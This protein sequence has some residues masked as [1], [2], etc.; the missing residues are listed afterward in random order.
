MLSTILSRRDFR[1][2]DQIISLYTLEQGKVEVLARGVKKI[3]SK[4]SAH[5]EPFSLIE[6]EIIPGK[7]LNHLGTVQP[8][9]YFSNIRAD[10][11]KSLASSFIIS[12]LDKILHA[13]ERDERIFILLRSFL[14]FI[15]IQ[16]SIFNIQLL[17][18]FIVKLLHCLGFDITQA[19]NL[20]DMMKKDLEVLNSGEWQVI[21]RYQIASNKK[22]LLHNFIY[23]FTQFH[24]ERKVRDWA[25]LKII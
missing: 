23:Q 17:D 10:L 13:G 22:Q 4:N 25:G 15:N 1:E 21:S 9:N 7:E 3:L 18:G 6:A 16:Y 8:V 11:Q 20:D 5:L 14:E 24:L 19:E 2:F 12:L